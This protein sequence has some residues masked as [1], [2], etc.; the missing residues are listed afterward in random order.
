MVQEN[1]YPF[2]S[3]GKLLMGCFS[4]NE[5]A[6]NSNLPSIAVSNCIDIVKGNADSLIKDIAYKSAGN[7]F[8]PLN[9]SFQFINAAQIFV[10]EGA[11]IENCI[12]N[13]SEGAIYIS[14]NVLIMDGAILRGPIFIGE[15]SVVKAG[16]TIYGG[17]S[18]GR[19]CTV[20]GEIKNAIINDYSNK[21]H[22]G[23]LGDSIIGEGCNLGAGTTNSNIKNN[24]ST[25]KLQ[26]G[27]AVLEAGQKFGMLM[28]DF[29]K[30]AINTSFN[31]GT[32][33]GWGC[34]VFTSGLTPTFIP[35]CSWGCEGQRYEFERLVTDI[36]TWL[37]FK[38]V[39]FDDEIK[40]LQTAYEEL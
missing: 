34:N 1:F 38:N 21:A 6:A 39:L 4:F 3:K 28:G 9:D 13:A 14:K 12:L 20:G 7:N 36:K 24:A 11:N 37:G 31:T 19:Q 25:I 8:V 16:A 17:T 5:R 18:I 22:Y 33:V 2:F 29:S 26:L 10:E 27:N 40:L 32:V 15:Q 35:P 23:Y 30:A